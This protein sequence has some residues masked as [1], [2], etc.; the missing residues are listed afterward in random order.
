MDQKRFSELCAIHRNCVR[1]RVGIGMLG[2]KTVH[3]V[4][5]DY[6]EEDKNFQE[7]KIGKYYA[8]IA[9]E[10]QIFEIQTRELYRLSDKI[11]TFIV[12]NSVTVV[13]PIIASKRIFW[14]E[15]F[16]GECISNRKSSKKGSEFDLLSELYGLRNFL[17][18]KNFRVCAVLLEVNEYRAQDGYGKDKKKRATKLDCL[19]VSLQDEFYLENPEDYR[20]FLP[21]TLPKIF[22]SSDFCLAANCKLFIA[23]R[24]LNILTKIGLLHIVG[25][26]GRKNKYEILD[27]S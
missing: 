26:D 10:G 6:F 1:E 9:K 17:L 23:H 24:A 19:P 14:M 13:Y 15:P 4:L 3:A 2:E 5:K 20:R 12:E 8:D 16:T 25:K 22:T 21:K 18:H 11:S 27:F 7:V